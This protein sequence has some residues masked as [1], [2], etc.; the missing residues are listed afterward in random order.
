M[1]TRLRIDY[2]QYCSDLNQSSWEN[3][4]DANHAFENG[5]ILLLSD[6]AWYIAAQGFRI[7]EIE[8][9][10]HTLS[11]LDLTPVAFSPHLKT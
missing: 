4:R 7:C 11:D 6:L 8:L 2:W 9:G 10:L 1:I 5:L 3:G